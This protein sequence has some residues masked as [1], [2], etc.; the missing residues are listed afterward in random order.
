MAA[1]ID[2][3]RSQDVA[4]RPGPR[5]GKAVRECAAPPELVAAAYCAAA[6]GEWDPGG[7]G[8][9]REN[10]SLHVVFA[11]IAGFEQSQASRRYWQDVAIRTVERHAEATAPEIERSPEADS[12]TAAEAGRVWAAALA[13]LR[14]GMTQANFEA[15][16]GATRA[17]AFEDDQM[18][19][20]VG[21]PLVRDT[22]DARFRQH[23]LRA[24]FDAVGRPCL[25]R[26]VVGRAQVT[27]TAPAA[28][29][30]GSA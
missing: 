1:I 15:N 8:W 24:L 9:L 7:T 17:V 4:I 26:V 30:E 25:L 12:P 14:L 20:A 10:L 21:S 27:A 22:L 16:L 19:V 23:I 18:T 11:R 6:R 28:V 2:L 13:E 5:D 3:V 29:A